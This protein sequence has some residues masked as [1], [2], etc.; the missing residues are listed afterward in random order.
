MKELG[1]FGMKRLLTLMKKKR[2]LI[3]GVL[4][5]LLTA[6]FWCLHIGKEEQSIHAAPSDFE[7]KGSFGKYGY[8]RLQDDKRSK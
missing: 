3:A 5:L 8:D 4:V 1:G 6:A 2:F 7:I